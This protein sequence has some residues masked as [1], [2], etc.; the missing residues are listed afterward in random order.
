MRTRLL[1]GVLAVVISGPAAMGQVDR[2][3]K[4]ESR[5]A[6][7]PSVDPSGKSAASDEL[8]GARSEVYKQVGEIKLKMHI[9]YPVNHKPTDRRAAIVFFFGGGWRHGSARQFQH[10][11]RYLASRGM[12][13]MSAEYRVSSRHKAKVVDCVADAKSAVRWARS[14]AKRL[15]VDPDRIAAGGGSAGGHLAATTATLPEFDEPSEGKSI[16]S[17]PNALVLFNPA[18]DLTPKGFKVDA[19]N[20]RYAER[21]SR[22][23]AD[24]KELS[25][26]H[27]IGRDTPPA[28]I[29]HGKQDTTVP[30]AQVQ[31]FTEAMKK[32]GRRCELAGFE[33]Q[34]HGFF[35]YGR[36]GNKMF[37]ATMR[38]VDEFLVSLKY[39]GKRG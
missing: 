32:A 34:G 3:A 12:V 30:Y 14:N 23:G 37:V 28:I 36:R 6:S 39:L 26:R 29:L 24:P 13:A 25:P 17:R 15:G 1:V 11:C 5:P 33:G 19:N 22:F 16:S 31:A 38:Q 4:P 8:P 18:L 35:N 7:S 27:H 21:A 20:K 9:F 10:Q 2:A